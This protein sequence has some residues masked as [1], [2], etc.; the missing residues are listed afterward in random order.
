MFIP[1]NVHNT[2]QTLASELLQLKIMLQLQYSKSALVFQPLH[3][4]LTCPASQC[5]VKNS[6]TRFYTT[7]YS[8][9]AVHPCDHLGHSLLGWPL[10]LIPW[11]P[12]SAAKLGKGRGTYD[13]WRRALMKSKHLNHSDL[14]LSLY[15]DLITPYN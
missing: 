12:I 5:T 13:I 1:F 7:W 9:S 15:I 4:T 10:D 8:R 2:R 3:V 6:V 11:K 14:V